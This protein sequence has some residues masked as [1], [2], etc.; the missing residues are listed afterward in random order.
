MR[1]TLSEPR[2]FVE[3]GLDRR[4]AG[5]DLV[6]HEGLLF[7]TRSIG[8]ELLRAPAEPGALKRLQHEVSRAIRSAAVV[9]NAFRSAFSAPS[10]SARAAF[11]TMA[12]TIAF[13]ASTSSGSVR[14]GG[15]MTPIRAYFAGNFPPY[16]V[17]IHSA[18]EGLPNKLRAFHWH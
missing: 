16:R 6:E 8:S 14:S 5:F 4:D 7:I 11:S 1:L 3:L 15:V 2:A 18:A 13:S 12:S 17:L 9:F 10:A